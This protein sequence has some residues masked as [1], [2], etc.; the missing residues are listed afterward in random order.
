MRG[1]GLE[2]QE[3]PAT[4]DR[5]LDAVRRAAHVS[6]EVRLMKSMARDA[7]EEGAH[8]AKRL[9]RRMRHGVERFEDLRDDTAH[10]VKREPLKAVALAAGAGLLVG[11][12]VGLLARGMGRTRHASRGSSSMRPVE[13]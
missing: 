13:M 3:R 9:L 7:G 6:H 2:I 12:A 10:R 1:T 8:A 4:T 11:I 5:V